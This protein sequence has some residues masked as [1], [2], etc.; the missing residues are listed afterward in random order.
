MIYLL[1]TGPLVGLLNRNDPWSSWCVGVL[2]QL[3]PPF[4][5]C[6]A[7]LAEASHFLGSMAQVCQLLEE[8]EM[9]IA[10]EAKHERRRLCQL[11]SKYSQMSFTDAC[12]IRMAEIH[13]DSIVWTL[14]RQDFSAYRLRQR[15]PVRFIAPGV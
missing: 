15:E 12:I 9:V 2:E 14:D 1:D 13:R 6:E 11:M 5:T 7:V 3:A 4:Y 10:F 8:G